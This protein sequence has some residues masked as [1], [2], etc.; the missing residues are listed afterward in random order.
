MKNLFCVFVSLVI[1]VFSFNFTIVAESNQNISISAKAYVLMEAKTGRVL[2]SKNADTKLPMASTTKIMT[3][4]LCLESG[5]LDEEFVVDSEAIKVEGSTMGLTEGDV[6]TKR[7][8]CYGMLLPSGN[9][10]ANAAAVKIAGSY[11]NFANLMNER[12]KEIGMTRT[13]FVTPSGLDAPGHGSS[14]YDM[15]LLAREALRNPEFREICSQK[16]A[17][18]RFGNPPYE[19]WLTN[20][21]KLLGLCPGVIGV[22]TGFTD[23]AGRCLVSACERNG[24]TL[25]CVTLN[26]SNDWQDH[27]ALYDNGFSLV[28]Q[29][30]LEQT[31]DLAID[32][33]GSEVDSVT[34]GSE[35]KI[36]I[37]MIGDEF[38]KITT[39]AILPPFVYAPVTI[40]DEVGR[41][42]FYYED[43]YIDSI[44]LYML[45]STE[46]YEPK[47]NENKLE[48]IISKIK[49]A[50]GM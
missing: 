50:L 36:T 12:A 26:A 15:A 17:K 45:E 20:T 8:L 9:D 7:A 33:V 22:K 46:L 21:N 13:C 11:E 32:V 5:G 27:T 44:P 29:K 41:L 3:T 38:D 37:G 19:R 49:R 47:Q 6:V 40:G 30:V 23:A 24:V 16:K 10:A 48:K 39:K 28:N 31:E 18:L 4:L 34:I 1:C 42:E 25:I 35:D 43:K 2:Y 14:A